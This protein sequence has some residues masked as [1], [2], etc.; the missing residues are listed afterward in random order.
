[1]QTK[2]PLPWF[3]LKDLTYSYSPVQLSTRRHLL[4]HHCDPLNSDTMP[5]EITRLLRIAY[6]RALNTVRENTVFRKNQH[7]PIQNPTRTS[8][9]PPNDNARL[10]ALENNGSQ[11][12]ISVMVELPSGVN[13][14][15]ENANLS[16][17]ENGTEEA[18]YTENGI[19][20]F[21][22]DDE[23][24]KPC[25]AMFITENLAYAQI[26]LAKADTRRQT[27]VK[28]LRRVEDRLHGLKARI[29]DEDKSS[30]PSTSI[31]PI[32]ESEEN[33]KL[34]AK[35]TKLEKTAKR[36]RSSIEALDVSIGIY[37]KE[38]QR[39]FE[40]AMI[41]SGL[42]DVPEYE[43]SVSDGASDQQSQEN[44]KEED[45]PAPEKPKGPEIS[46]E[47]KAIKEARNKFWQAEQAYM[48]K[49]REFDMKEYHS[50]MQLRS[51]EEALK[52]GAAGE[53]TQSEF[54]RRDLYGKMWLTASLIGKEKERDQLREEAEELGAF[55]DGWGQESYYGDSQATML[56]YQDG[57]HP[58]EGYRAAV[59]KPATIN[60]IESWVENTDVN[61]S[62][63][64]VTDDQ[65]DE[66]EAGPVGFSDSLSVVD[67]T[68]NA[69]NI[70]KWEY[71]REEA[72][73]CWPDGLGDTEDV[74]EVDDALDERQ[75][76]HSV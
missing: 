45:I 25:F 35:I 18:D 37:T 6:D 43:E 73:E 50:A 23:S 12:S 28:T 10:P 75:R 57:E 27:K 70:A 61:D 46:D 30:S 29:R 44:V 14:S 76:A 54:D 32:E 33:K 42:Q 21:V 53:H 2:L 51:F 67:M 58:E 69:K 62:P 39:T 72:R 11:T 66:W 47:E 9:H 24:D 56:S 20:I 1:M 71:I 60:F 17:V 63:D 5:A 65:E 38:I 41:E 3:R 64:V 74:D 40:K 52:N 7:I 26:D 49:L 59:L 16:Q 36:L 34:K 31:E 4:P 55:D 13:R 19:K 68:S 8:A 15:E 22:S 48:C